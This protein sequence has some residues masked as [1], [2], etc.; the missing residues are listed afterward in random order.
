MNRFGRSLL[1]VLTAALWLAAGRAALADNVVITY[2]PAGETAPEFTNICNNIGSNRCY[3]GLE[4]FT[5]FTISSP[6][7]FSSNFTDGASQLPISGGSFSGQYTV[8]TGTSYGSGKAWV[9]KPQDQYGGVNGK[10]YPELF[11]CTTSLGCTSGATATY[12]LSLSRSGSIPGVNY[13]GIWI[14]ALDASN[15]LTIYSGD[16]VIAYFDSS[17]LQ[18]ALGSCTGANP[19]CGNPTTQF[20]GQDPGELF[21][22]VNIYDLSGYITKVV[23]QN[24]NSGTG[25]E[26]SDHAVAYGD[27]LTVVGT[28]IPEPGT[29]AVLGVGFAGLAAARRRLPRIGRRA[30]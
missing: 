6:G 22:Y 8:G 28:P 20:K 29:L 21:V 17:V 25:F 12:T 10:P 11:G 4:N 13:F 2:S 1:L 14:S 16:T 15:E 19:Y 7:V 9:N 23:F 30:S 5:G 24:G 27:P 3:Y 26:S 18:R